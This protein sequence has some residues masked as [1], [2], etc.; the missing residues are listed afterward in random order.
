MTQSSTSNER[1]GT[2]L[3]GRVDY[4]L[5][6]RISEEAKKR[7]ISTSKFTA[8]LIAIGFDSKAQ[9]KA[10]HDREL[11]AVGQFIR[12]L[13]KGSEAKMNELIELYNRLKTQLP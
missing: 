3:S 12:T 4:Q 5:A 2:P 8:I 6:E 1:Y 11:E 10:A 7:D 13:A 9:L